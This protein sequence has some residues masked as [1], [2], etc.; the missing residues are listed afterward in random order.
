[1]NFSVSGNSLVTLLNND[2]VKTAKAF[3]SHRLFPRDARTSEAQKTARCT[4]GGDAH[5]QGHERA[6]SSEREQLL[7][8]CTLGTSLASAWSWPCSQVCGKSS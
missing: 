7:K 3:Y 8:A 6:A 1:M 5:S 4:L 2:A